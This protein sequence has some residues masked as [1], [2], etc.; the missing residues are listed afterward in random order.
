MLPNHRMFKAVS[1]VGVVIAVGLVLLGWALIP[2]TSPVSVAGVCA[3]LIIYGAVFYFLLPRVSPDV[4]KWARLFGLLA[5]AVFAAEVLLEYALLPENNTSWGIA[6]F[7]LVFA[8]YFFS[9]FWAAYRSHRLGTGVLTAVLSAMVSSL[10]W[11]IVVLAVFY[12]FRGSDRQAQV[13]LSEG[14]YEDFT[15]SRMASI[16]TFIMEDFLGGAF[17]HLLLG[18]A[19]AAL[20]GLLG[21]AIG[22]LVARAAKS[23]FVHG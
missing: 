3:I 14:N 9:S 15:R 22:K 11:L 7:G 10:L 2:A 21:G 19:I 23:S 17:F 8:L 18:P 1:L 4:A 5:G 20:L 12:V 16:E 6:E 13:F